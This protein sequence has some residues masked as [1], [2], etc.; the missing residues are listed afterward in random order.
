MLKDATKKANN[1]IEKGVQETQ[2]LLKTEE[3]SQ[4]QSI[5]DGTA[6]SRG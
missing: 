6:I 1:I 4:I 3:V 5:S 2:A